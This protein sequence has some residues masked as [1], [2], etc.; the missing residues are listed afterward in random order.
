[1]MDAFMNTSENKETK[2]AD[3]NKS[4]CI[5]KLVT[6]AILMLLRFFFHVRILVFHY[7]CYYFILFYFCFVIYILRT[8][9][10]IPFYIDIANHIYEFTPSFNT[11]YRMRVL[12]FLFD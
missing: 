9:I 1:M 2:N 3:K 10:V 4:S 5:V 12:C 7:Y 8:S 11:Y 6:D